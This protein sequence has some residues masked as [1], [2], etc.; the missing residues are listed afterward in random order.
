MK[1]KTLLTGAL[2]ALSLLPTL[3]G[4]GDEPTAQGVQTN[5]DYIWTL[6][7]AA[8]VFFMQAGFAWWRLVL[9]GPRT[10]SIL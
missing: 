5:L 8:L 2:L 4:A 1:K 10:P 6:I 7:A 3:A 9:P